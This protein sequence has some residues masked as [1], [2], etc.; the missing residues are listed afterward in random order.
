MSG[1]NVRRLRDSAV[2]K[3]GGL[4]KP[5]ST[6]AAV[7]LDVTFPSLAGK[8]YSKIKDVRRTKYRA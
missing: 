2:S 3:V 1:M 4:T 8:I 6:D 7:G 5:G